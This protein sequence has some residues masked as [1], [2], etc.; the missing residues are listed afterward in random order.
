MNNKKQAKVQVKTGLD[1]G[2]T[3]YSVNELLGVLLRKA[4][5]GRS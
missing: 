5:S 1:S 3:K 2:K 4:S